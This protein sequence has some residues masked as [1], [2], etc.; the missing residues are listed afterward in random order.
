MKH[1]I[2]L[3]FLV[4]LFVGCAEYGPKNYKGYAGIDY[5]A[6]ELPH[7]YTEIGLGTIRQGDSTEEEN[8][9]QDQDIDIETISTPEVEEITEEEIIESSNQAYGEA[10]VVMASKKIPLGKNAT[11]ADLAAFQTALDRSYNTILRSYRTQGFT[12]TLSPAGTVNPLS[13]INVQCLLSE[14]FANTSGKRVC[15]AFFNKIPVEYENEK[16]KKAI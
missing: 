10:V 5:T 16:L 3:I 1:L 15:D 2:L 11:G 6:Y 12:Y 4:T 8:K 13:L 14:N 9:A 7:S